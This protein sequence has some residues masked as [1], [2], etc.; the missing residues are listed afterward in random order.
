MSD[1]ES[2]PANSSTSG[3]KVALI[4]VGLLLLVGVGL[5]GHHH[6]TRNKRGHEKG[7]LNGEGLYARYCIRCHQADA[8]G[9]PDKYPDLLASKLTEEESL[10]RIKTGKDAM[11]AFGDWFPEDYG[12][13][14]TYVQ[15]LKK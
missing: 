6:A 12:L 15:S 1:Q 7:E 3:K 10:A 8:R 5:I 4:G 2:S 9:V 11:P 13:L 14:Q